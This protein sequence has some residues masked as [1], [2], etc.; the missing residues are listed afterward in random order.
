MRGL[1]IPTMKKMSINEVVEFRKPKHVYI[2][3]ICGNDTDITI[4]VK[5]G[6]YIALY[7]G[8]NKSVKI[9]GAPLK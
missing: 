5:V 4:K 8:E 6:N 1:K 9:R 2:P 7:I 3:L